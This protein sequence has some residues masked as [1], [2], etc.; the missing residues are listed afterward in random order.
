[1]WITNQLPDIPEA[2]RTSLVGYLLGLAEANQRQAELIQQ[3]RDEIA[4][5]K[6]EKGRPK[7]KP[8]GMMERSVPDADEGKDWGDESGGELGRESG[9][10]K[11]RRPG[12]SKRTKTQALGCSIWP[13]W[14]V[15]F[16]AVFM[17]N[18]ADS[19]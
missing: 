5:L 9:E 1:M 6:G 3:L 16:H 12:S 10:E 2:E 7:F 15:F 13:L 17:L 11:P 14:L 19:F 4:I 8:S 18:T